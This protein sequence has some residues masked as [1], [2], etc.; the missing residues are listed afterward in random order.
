MN[1]NPWLLIV[2]MAIVTY[3][4][5]MIPLLVLSKRTIPEKLE[6]WMS[7]I[8]VSIF[9]ALIFS[10]IFFWEGKLNSNPLINVKL[11]PSILV[12]IFAYY[13]K[14]LLWSM[15]LGVLS[16]TLMVYLF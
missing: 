6:K 10:D 15:A 2:G 5:R 8:P 4:P 16:I 12:F 13:T 14:N 9:S 11:L 1:S 3:L 7:F